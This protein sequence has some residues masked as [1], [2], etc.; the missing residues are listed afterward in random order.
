MIIKKINQTGRLSS[1]NLPENTEWVVWCY[2][3]LVK[4]K[5]YGEQPRVEVCFRALNSDKTISEAYRIQTCPLTDLALLRVGSIWENSVCTSQI[6]FEEKLYDVDFSYKNEGWIISSFNLNGQS[7]IYSAHDF[8]SDRID[9]DSW[10]LEFS[11][12]GGGKLIIPSLEFFYRTYGRSD[13][14][15]RTLLTYS[16]EDIC[17]RLF[18]SA[19]DNGRK[20]LYVK[21]RKRMYD[22]DAPF[23]AFCALDPFTQE[24]IKRIKSQMLIDGRKVYIKIAPWFRGQAQL[25]VKGVSFDQGRSFLGLIVTGYSLPDGFKIVHDRDN[26]N[27]VNEKADDDNKKAWDNMSGRRL[28]NE[29]DDFS[30]DN[31]FGP[32]GG[33][34]SLE[35]PAETL[36]I[37]GHGCTVVPLKK[38]KADSVSGSKSESVEH[39]SYSVNDKDNS[40]NDVGYLAGNTDGK[41]TVLMMESKGVVRDMWN[42]MRYFIDENQSIIRSLE[43]YTPE[44]SYSTHPEPRLVAIPEF[45]NQE[46]ADEKISRT[47][48]N[49]PYLDLLLKQEIRGFLVARMKFDMESIH[50]IEIQRRISH[51]N[52]N[53]SVSEDE[54]FRGMVFRLNNDDDIHDWVSLL[55][56]ELR[57]VK[58]VVQKMVVKCPG[59]AMVYK[60]STAKNEPVP[61]YSALIN[62][63]EKIGIKFLVF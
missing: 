57:H 46:I 63:L 52:T 26:T 51:D 8:P 23:V 13:E 59:V 27:R 36:E 43:W 33:S 9:K 28:T 29:G 5:R 56:H 10:Q 14:L 60:H 53:S 50:F 37:L 38:E 21:L 31:S 20:E 35:I 48:L 7:E 42:A 22:R 1:L 19:K 40:E 3:A 44:T 41:T 18:S 58:G 4:N 12:K 17:N 25:R 47:I 15:K 55:A 39:S 34:S 45:L 24:V 49:W 32:D 61:G 54:K 16:W 30:I 2:G 6:V 11:L 62:A